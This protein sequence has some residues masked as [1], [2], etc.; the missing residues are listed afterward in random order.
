MKSKHK[1]FAGITVILLVVGVW[2]WTA[3]A[4]ESGTAGACCA[5]K[6]AASMG[7]APGQ[8]AGGSGVACSDASCSAVGA[9]ATCEQLAGTALYLDSPSVILGKADTMGLSPVQKQQLQAIIAKARTE[10]LTVLTAGQKDLLGKIPAKPWVI[11][12]PAGI[13]S[14]AVAEQTMCPVMNAPINKA[15]FTEYNGQK[16]YFCCPGC[17]STFLKSPEKYLSKLPQFNM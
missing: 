10:A 13:E 17:K 8:A 6:A 7:G 14:A 16:V 4:Q 12:K 2:V 5:E 11:G 9:C 1:T 15:L 3:W